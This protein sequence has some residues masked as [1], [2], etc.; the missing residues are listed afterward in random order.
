MEEDPVLASSNAGGTRPWAA[1]GDQLWS[2][3]VSSLLCAT[4]MDVSREGAS[5]LAAR[6]QVSSTLVLCY[7]LSA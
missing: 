2:G 1:V 7:T 4:G 6:R 3:C 5:Q